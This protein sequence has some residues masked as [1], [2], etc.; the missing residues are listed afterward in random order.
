MP[1]SNNMFK[2]IVKS[3]PGSK[4][5]LLLILLLGL[6]LFAKT[7]KGAEYRTIEAYTYGRFTACYKAT[8]GAGQAATFFTYHELS[9]GIEDWNEIDIEILGRYNDDVQ[10]NTITSGQVN[11]VHHQYVGFD[12]SEDYHVYAFEW[13]PTYVAWFIDSVEVFRQT[14]GDVT[15]LNKPQKIMMNLWISS[16]TGWV[17]DFDARILPLFASYDWVSYDAYTPGSG[18]TGTDNN[19]TVTWRDDFST[20][21][22]TRWAKATHTFDGN[23]VDFL[24]ANIVFNDGKMTLCLTDATHTG[25]TDMNAP[26]I[27][28]ARF[29]DDSVFVQFS[30]AVEST[31]ATT[32]TNYS[33]NNTTIEEVNL[34]A[35]Q[36][37]VW[38]KVSGYDTSAN[39]NLTVQNV[40]DVFSN[41]LAS[42]TLEIYNPPEW[43]F[44]IRINVGGVAYG[45]FL[46]D[47]DWSEDRNYGH[48]AGYAGYFSG[49]AIANTEDDEIY[50]SELWEPVKY[51]VRVPNGIYRVT[52]LMAENYYT[53]AGKRMFAINVEG[54]YLAKYLDIYSRVGAHKALN[55]TAENVIVRDRML[56]IHFG[57]VRDYPLLNGV[58]IE[59]ISD[60]ING[61]SN[62]APRK[63]RLQPNYPNPFNS[64][65][66]ILYELAETARVDLSI[67]DT[68]GRKTTTLVDDIQQAGNYTIPWRPDVASGIYLCQLSAKTGGKNYLSTQKMLLI[69]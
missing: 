44:P 67:Y 68:C 20:W 41:S 28:W 32:I 55:L 1:L 64:A 2:S 54:N 22:Q 65:T 23:L 14:G 45:S 62:P 8:K 17:G 24:P 15:T 49:Q 42:Q 19:F 16:A 46:A 48:I 9:G 51:Q 25:Y 57:A 56:D 53:S 10:F 7:Y 50:R 35:N 13:T 69:K 36:R 63:F 30:E 29:A 6:S 33:I 5:S 37:T 31:S 11:H 34:A 27:A 39:A 66:T 59:K 26:Y 43:T 61:S 21:D 3:L 47:Q 38:L 60:K 18:N 12:P 4:R 58:I 40:K 52:L